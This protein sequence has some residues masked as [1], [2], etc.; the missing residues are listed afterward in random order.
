MNEC[1]NYIHKYKCDTYNENHDA[2]K[3]CEMRVVETVV[4]TIRHSEVENRYFIRSDSREIVSNALCD[5]ELF[6]AM[7]EFKDLG[8][9]EGFKVV[10]EVL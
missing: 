7:K 6:S 5:T 1:K 4:F 3:N 9:R 10:F 8:E 2:C